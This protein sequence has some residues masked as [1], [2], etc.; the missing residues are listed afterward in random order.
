VIGLLRWT[1]WILLGAVALAAL[2]SLNGHVDVILGG[3]ALVMPLGLVIAGLLVTG[4]LIRWWSRAWRFIWRDQTRRA[5]AAERALARGHVAAAAGRVDDSLK[6]AQKAGKSAAGLSVAARILAAESAEAAGRADLAADAYEALAQDPV[7]R[8]LGLK[9]QLRLALAAGDSARARPLAEEAFGLEPGSAVGADA[10]IALAAGQG[11]FDTARQVVDRALRAGA[12]DRGLAKRRRALLCYAQAEGL[13]AQGTLGNADR[14]RARDLAVEAMELA[15]DMPP[16]VI[17]AAKA[18]FDAG[19]LDV[20]LKILAD[21]FTAQPHPDLVRAAADLGATSTPSLIRARIDT[22]VRH[23]PNHLE[24]HL[25][26]AR[27]A[28]DADEFSLA[29]DHLEPLLGPQSRNGADGLGLRA[30]ILMARL[31]RDGRT[32]SDPAA[33]R[34]AAAW[35]AQAECGPRDDAWICRACGERQQSWHATCPRC[36]GLDSF[37]WPDAGDVTAPP[38]SRQP[39]LTAIP[40]ARALDDPGLEP[41]ESAPSLWSRAK[42]LFTRSA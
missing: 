8:F 29:R 7:T 39:R 35:L 2:L 22:L 4:L 40:N 3:Y 24:S 32:A 37:D 14:R 1:L 41:S 42:G 11:D 17:A 25:A 28:L 16:F 20:A 10:L 12:F 9:G 23:R 13:Y 6:S 18:E 30:S 19:S 33:R 31:S 34:E 15:R 38:K 5:R 21:G 36:G 27:V 26:L